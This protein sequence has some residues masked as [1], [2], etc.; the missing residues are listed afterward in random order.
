MVKTNSIIK[1]FIEESGLPTPTPEIEHER[2]LAIYD[3]LQKNEFSIDTKLVNPAPDGPYVLRLA[4]KNSL[5]LFIIKDQASE[6]EYEIH[7][8]LTPLRPII[9]DYFD[10][11]QSYFN[12]VKRLPPS[13]IETID[14]GRRGI[15]LE[16]S[17][18]L[19][20]RLD[21]KVRTD[22][23]TAKRLFTLVCALH[24]K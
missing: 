23:Q 9:R 22:I 3:I 5:L 18:T 24:F 15:H 7:L 17:Q 1:I 14:M 20:D 6:A 13:Q 2:N 11:C 16:G 19:I 8:S 21:G 4:I 12:A 10:I